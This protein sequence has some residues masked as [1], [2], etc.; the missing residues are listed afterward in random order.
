MVANAPSGALAAPL[1]WGTH[2]ARE[3]VVCTKMI[4]QWHRRQFSADWER[5]VAATPSIILLPDN[6][7]R[8]LCRLINADSWGVLAESAGSPPLPGRCLRAYQASY[9][10]EQA[11]MLSMS[12]PQLPSQPSACEEPSCGLWAWVVLPWCQSQL[13]SSSLAW[14]LWEK[15]CLYFQEPVN[16]YLKHFVTI[17]FY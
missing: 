10:E 7:I 8:I 1:C 9:S 5:T 16:H 4:S 13:Y 6:S 17:N 11:Q 3:G 14:P 15:S 2:G 12:Q